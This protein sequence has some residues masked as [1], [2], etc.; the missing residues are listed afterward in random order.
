MSGRACLGDTPG[1]LPGQHQESPGEGELLMGQVLIRPAAWGL[2]FVAK[3]R[4]VPR[5]CS[6]QEGEDTVRT[7][8]VG[9]TEVPAWA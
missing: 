3:V 5:R 8:V 7:G 4:G 1:K 6:S 2:V 9:H